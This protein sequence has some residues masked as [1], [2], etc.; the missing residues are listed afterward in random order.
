MKRIEIRD[1]L[2]DE[3]ANGFVVDDAVADAVLTLLMALF[4]DKTGPVK[5]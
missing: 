5:K 4:A 3:N 1:Y 2:K